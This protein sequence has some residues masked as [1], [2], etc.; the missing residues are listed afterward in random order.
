[1][2]FQGL[3]CGGG[4]EMN[5]ASARRR[6]RRQEYLTRLAK[7]NP[8]KFR[9]EWTKRLDSWSREADWRAKRLTD[10]KGNP[11]PMAFD[12][13][14]Q[15]LDE[16]NG[17]GPEAV[18]LEGGGTLEVMTNACCQAVA[19]A[20]DQRLYRLSNVRANCVRMAVDGL[21]PQMKT[22]TT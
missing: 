2:L 17:C 22:E 11:V 1:M 16:L 5:K 10:E 19:K 8:E 14:G 12:L 9:T 20:I 7:K 21:E 6:K 13:V 3:F 15:A 4:E 18:N